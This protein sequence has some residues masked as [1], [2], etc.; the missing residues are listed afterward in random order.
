MYRNERV[1]LKYFFDITSI[2][3]YLILLFSLEGAI[4]RN[5]Q[6]LK[7]KTDKADSFVKIKCPDAK[8][9]KD[10]HSQ[11]SIPSVKKKDVRDYLPYPSKKFLIPGK[12]LYDSHWLIYI[13]H[14]K[15]NNGFHYI[16]GKV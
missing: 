7:R 1:I 15:D 11:T 16:R 12:R 6:N 10:I 4:Y 3:V 5:H 2:E 8:T 14:A 13:R 9:Y